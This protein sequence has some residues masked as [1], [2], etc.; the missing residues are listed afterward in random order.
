[1]FIYMFIYMFMFIYIYIYNR[2][3]PSPKFGGYF[4]THVL[5]FVLDRHG[6]FEHGY[7][8]V[9]Q[10]HRLKQIIAIVIHDVAE[11]AVAVDNVVVLVADKLR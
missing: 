11:A 10:F 1:M 4:Q 5:A 9:G 6:A 7:V 2:M 8:R 3:I